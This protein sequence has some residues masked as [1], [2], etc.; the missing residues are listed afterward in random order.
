MEMNSVMATEIVAAEVEST[1]CCRKSSALSKP[2][3]CWGFRRI[4]CGGFAKRFPA[5]HF[6]PASSGTSTW[7]NWLIITTMRGELPQDKSTKAPQC[8]EC[9]AFRRQPTA[10]IKVA[11]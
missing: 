4:A 9:R 1:L 10:F 8:Q 3:E 2:A 11:V 7:E 5:W 6:S